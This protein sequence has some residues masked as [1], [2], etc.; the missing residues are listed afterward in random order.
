MNHP[1]SPVPESWLPRR[2]PSR[3]RAPAGAV[4][5][6]PPRRMSSANA[7]GLLILLLLVLLILVLILILLLLLI[8]PWLPYRPPSTSLYD[9]KGASACSPRFSDPP[10]TPPP[11]SREYNPS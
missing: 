5:H 6:C 9:P 4:C 11:F 2:R 3:R 10:L 8:F 7:R 1:A